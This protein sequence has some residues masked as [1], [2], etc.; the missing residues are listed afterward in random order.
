LRREVLRMCP[1]E[2]KAMMTFLPSFAPTR[3]DAPDGNR[4]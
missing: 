4:S 3:A 2:D 1:S